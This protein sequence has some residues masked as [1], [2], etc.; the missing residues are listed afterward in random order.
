M[1]RNLRACIARLD[2][3]PRIQHRPHRCGSHNQTPPFRIGPDKQMTLRA[4]GGEGEREREREEAKRNGDRRRC[5]WS[6]RGSYALCA[7]AGYDGA[8]GAGG[9][10][11]GSENGA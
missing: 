9:S 11:K 5:R 6:A 1:T 7:A 4:R 3:L 2:L 8:A 10:V